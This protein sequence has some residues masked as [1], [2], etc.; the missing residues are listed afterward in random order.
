MASVGFP[1]QRISWEADDSLKRYRKGTA[2]RLFCSNCGSPVAQEHDSAADLTF[3]N[4]GFMD[5][6]N[7]FPPT[8]HTFAGQKLTWLKLQDDLPKCEKTLLIKTD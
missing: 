8:Y 4:T 3:F 2:T 6:P 7:N 5:E 1:K